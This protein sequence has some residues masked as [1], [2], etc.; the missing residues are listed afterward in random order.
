MKKITKIF[1]TVSITAFAVSL[2]GPGSELGYG[3]LK[4][5]AAITFIAFFITNLLAKQFDE[6]DA[7]EKTR[8]T[9]AQRQTSCDSAA[10]VGSPSG[11]RGSSHAL[12]PVVA[13]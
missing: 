10:E 1:L 5:L 9:L 2:T 3:F 13:G 7:E 12:S 8:R 4:P 6:F 11:T